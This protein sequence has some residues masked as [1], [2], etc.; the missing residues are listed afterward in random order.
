MT[1]LTDI[2]STRQAYH[3]KKIGLGPM[4]WLGACLKRRDS[5]VDLCVVTRDTCSELSIKNGEKNENVEGG[6]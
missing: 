4:A 1:S 6:G 2:N 3:R 5:G